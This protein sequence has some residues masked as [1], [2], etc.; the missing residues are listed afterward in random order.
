LAAT[1]TL[2]S[3]PG[4]GQPIRNGIVTRPRSE[5]VAP[6]AEPLNTGGVEQRG[7]TPRHVAVQLTVPVSQS[8]PLGRS[9]GGLQTSLVIL[10]V[11]R[12]P[13]SW[14]NEPLISTGG[15]VLLNA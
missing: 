4:A 8:D 3:T 2:Q 12:A 7:V 11:P 15:V 9:P 5:T 14:S 6:A 10:K 1:E 13:L